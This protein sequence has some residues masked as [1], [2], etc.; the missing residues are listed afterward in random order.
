M[1]VKTTFTLTCVKKGQIIDAQHYGCK[2]NNDTN[3][4]EEKGK[5]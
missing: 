4:G 2:N 1:D 3:L 5:I